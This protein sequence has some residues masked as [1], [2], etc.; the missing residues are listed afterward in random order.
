MK[1]YIYVYM[2]FII[3]DVEWPENYQK[4]GLAHNHQTFSLY[5]KDHLPRQHKQWIMDI[6]YKH[7]I[8]YEKLSK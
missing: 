1:S 2:N 7:I 8:K 3:D 4:H 6:H 5:P